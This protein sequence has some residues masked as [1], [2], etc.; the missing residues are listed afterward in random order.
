MNKIPMTIKGSK[1]LIKELNQLK[2]VK[3]YE[4]IND[5]ME[6]RKYGDLKENAEYHAAREEQSFCEKR[7]KE[8]ELKLS[9][10]QIIDITKIKNKGRVIFGS[11]VD[12]IN[13]TTNKIV[14]YKIVGDD[15][16]NLKEYLISINAPIARG[17]IGKKINDTV[18]IKTPKGNIIFKILKIQYLDK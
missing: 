12:L 6:A 14:S 2:N 9:N 10:C 5:I 8:I 7:I 11:T 17:L 3:R 15:E 13:I 1:K 4:I 16:A 18:L